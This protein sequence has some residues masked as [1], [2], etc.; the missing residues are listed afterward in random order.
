MRKRK[1]EKLRKR[2]LV[3]LNPDHNKSSLCTV[4]SVS[5]EKGLKPFMSRSVGDSQEGQEVAGEADD[6]IDDA[7]DS[8]NP[9]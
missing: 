6:G 4:L 8:G 3:G 5:Y 9:S 7:P 2:S 1:S